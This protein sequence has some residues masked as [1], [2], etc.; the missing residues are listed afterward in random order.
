MTETSTRSSGW[1]DL[2]GKRQWWDGTSWQKVPKSSEALHDNPYLPGL[3]V[4]GFILFIVGGGFLIAGSNATSD[5]DSS[6]VNFP[7]MFM[8]DGIGICTCILGAAFLIAW[9]VAGAVGW[10]LKRL[11]DV[12]SVEAT[13]GRRADAHN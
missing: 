3:A 1:Y 10:Y 2:G 13:G 4:A 6:I 9:C 5:S 12:F 8:L 11:T 7:S